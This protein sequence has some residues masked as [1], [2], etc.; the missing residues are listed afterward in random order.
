MQNKVVLSPAEVHVPTRGLARVIGKLH[1]RG[2][3]L[4]DDKGNPAFCSQCGAVI[5]SNEAHTATET[6]S[7]PAVFRCER[8]A[9]IVEGGSQR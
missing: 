9:G 3:F 4:R 1:Q 2:H 8:C 5:F 6:G 7:G